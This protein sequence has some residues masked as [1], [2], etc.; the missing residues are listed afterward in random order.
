MTD[1][2]AAREGRGDGSTSAAA[3]AAA[4]TAATTIPNQV[5]VQKGK[6]IQTPKE[7]LQ[8]QNSEPPPPPPPPPSSSSSTMADVLL[9]EVT[10]T[11][12][13]QL[14]AETP[15]NYKRSLRRASL[16][17]HE[18]N[19]TNNNNNRTQRP[20]FNG[21]YVPVKPV[22]IP[23]PRLLL[24]SRDVAE[25]LLQLAPQHV[26]SS[27]FL[28]YV[29]GNFDAVEQELLKE[30]ES[31]ADKAEASSTS[32]AAAPLPLPPALVS[33][34]TPYALSIMGTRYTSNCPY[35]TG[36]GY[37]DGRAVS[38][39]EMRGHE[40]QLK[41]G[42]TTPFCR[43]ADGKAVLRSSVREF[44]ASEATHHLGVST[45]RALSLVVSETELVNRPWYSEADS[46]SSSSSN[47]NLSRRSS[48]PRRTL[49]S[50]DDPRLA[51]YSLEDR[52]RIVAQLRQQKD[53]PNV[54]IREPTA[55]T[56]RVSPSFV[57]IGHLDLFARRAEKASMANADKTRSR[58]D[59]STP[60]WKELELMV[61]HACF[62]E[63]KEAAYDPFVAQS[64][65]AAAGAALLRE[66]ATRIAA[67]VAGWIRVGFAQGNFNGDN[68]LVAGRTMDYGPF[69]FMEEYSPVFAKWT[70]TNVGS[71]FLVSCCLPFDHDGLACAA[72]CAKVDVGSPF[73]F[74]DS[75]RQGAETTLAS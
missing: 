44:L 15:D 2:A 24:Y 5:L 69:G 4:T 36:D 21:H 39:G 51:Q 25:Q 12:M 26:Q 53:D 64:D 37:G 19:D 16:P 28:S 48:H 30:S 11:W 59:A 13:E 32:P 38:I 71:L 68:C 60:E 46:A 61:W 72:M 45:T 74:V 35:G 56:C 42:G 31:E 3:T 66:S 29:S 54:M 6:A 22:G 20:V 62:R 34:A 57:R 49:P 40:L 67:M 47:A 43:G 23:N 33:W 73:S 55:I 63:F 14:R 50:L 65:V 9:S 41:G 17:E 10:S 1:E 18:H 52:K 8:Q 70:G 75:C 27:V 58:W 7:E